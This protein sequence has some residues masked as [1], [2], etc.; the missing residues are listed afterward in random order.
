MDVAEQ[1]AR[2][3][4]ELFSSKLISSQSIGFVLFVGLSILDELV[5]DT[6]LHIEWHLG[7]CML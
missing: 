5:W 3:K 4:Q 2:F 6:S 7:F 1:S